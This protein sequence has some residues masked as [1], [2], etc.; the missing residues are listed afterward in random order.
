M[1]PVSHF[2]YYFQTSVSEGFSI[3]S[4]FVVWLA[5]SVET[6]DS[7]ILIQQN[8]WPLQLATCDNQPQYFKTFIIFLKEKW[9]SC[10]VKY[11]M[12][13]DLTLTLGGYESNKPYVYYITTLLYEWVVRCFYYINLMCML[14]GYC[15]FVCH[16]YI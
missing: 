6:W 7:P 3:S 14:S 5:M 16:I 12:K 13:R 2:N 1:V 8:N 10:C 15:H 11:C 4:A 9:S